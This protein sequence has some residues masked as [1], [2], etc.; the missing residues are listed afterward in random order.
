M[1]ILWELNPTKYLEDS[2]SCLM[3]SNHYPLGWV[4]YTHVYKKGAN[5]MVDAL[6]EEE[7]HRI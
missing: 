3:K 1:A 7:I 2:I 6:T 5:K 4:Y